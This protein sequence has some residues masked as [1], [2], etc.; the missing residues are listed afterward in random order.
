M[1]M[2]E[3]EENMNMAEYK[4]K[5]LTTLVEEPNFTIW[6]KFIHIAYSHTTEL[7]IYRSMKENVRQRTQPTTCKYNVIYNL[8]R[9][10]LISKNNLKSNKK[11]QNKTK[12]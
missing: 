5:A 7:T 3:K 1:K 10:F 9:W 12:T 2:R 8:G 11:T 6:F 4:T